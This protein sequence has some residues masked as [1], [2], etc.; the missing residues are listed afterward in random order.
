[1]SD[2]TEGVRLQK[3]L[4]AAGVAS[5]RASE[6]MIDEGRVEVNG[7]IVT[8]QGRRVN[9]DRDQIRVDGSRIPPPRRHMYL[10]LN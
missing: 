5:R 9:P 6:I 4:A 7:K 1:M 10:V 3:V 2:E 8:E